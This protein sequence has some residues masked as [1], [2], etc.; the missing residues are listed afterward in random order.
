MSTNNDTEGGCI[1]MYE[2]HIRPARDLRNNF[3]EI[4]RLV[5]RKD[6]VIITKHGRGDMVLIDYDEF[7]SYENYLREQYI[8]SELRKDAIEMEKP[9]AEYYSVEEAFRL[10]MSD[11]EI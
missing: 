10:A 2:T 3:P 5:A 7:K 1:E 9:D 8:A 6:Q 4:S 11:D